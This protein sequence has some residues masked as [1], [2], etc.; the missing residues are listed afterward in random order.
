MLKGINRNVIVVKTDPKSR[1]EA[2]YFVLKR[3]GITNRADIVKEANKIIAESGAQSKASRPNARTVL[4]MLGSAA[5]GAAVSL[6][7]CLAVLL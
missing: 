4:L 6:G 1:F 7:V 2:V 5:L 3:D